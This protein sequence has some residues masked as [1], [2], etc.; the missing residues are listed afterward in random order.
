MAK[1]Q[2]VFERYLNVY[3][4]AQYLCFMRYFLNTDI[5]F[6][7]I[8]E[9]LIMQKNILKNVLLCVSINKRPPE[10]EYSR[11]FFSALI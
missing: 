5:N 2:G 1:Q 4:T 9:W 8:S 10:R 3:F 11:L 6:S 7:R